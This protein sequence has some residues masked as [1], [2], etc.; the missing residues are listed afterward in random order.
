[1]RNIYIIIHVDYCGTNK[2][3][4]ASLDPLLSQFSPSPNMVEKLED[5]NINLSIVICTGIPFLYTTTTTN[6]FIIPLG[7]SSLPSYPSFLLP[8]R[9]ISLFITAVSLFL[10]AILLF[11]MHHSTRVASIYGH[12][13][14]AVLP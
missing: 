14:H 5:K 13:L 11:L 4:Y 10:A 7:V 1:M 2:Y 6:F 3:F 8:Y 9:H 12:Q